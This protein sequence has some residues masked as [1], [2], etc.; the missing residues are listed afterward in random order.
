MLIRTF[1]AIPALMLAACAVSPLAANAD[2]SNS[3]AQN[4]SGSQ[5]RH[6][7]V[8]IISMF[9][10][11]GQVWLDHLGP[12]QEITVAGLSPDYPTVHCNKQDIC[13]MTTG[14]GHANAAASTMALTFS[15]KF[16]L[17][18]T[19]FMVAGIAGIDPLRGTVGSAAWAKYLVDFGIQW[20]I[21]GREIPPGWTTGYLGINTTGPTQ[22][23]PLDY[24]TEV[25][26]LNTQLADA[27]F[28]LSRNVTLED[29]AQA[30]AAR[31]KFSYA[32]ANQPPSVIQC[33]TLAGDT[34]WSGT[35]LG[36]R[37]RD[38]T[39]ILTDGKGVY[40]TT[41][42]EDNSTYEALTRAATVKRVDLSRV[43]VLRSGSDFDRPYAGQTSADNLLNYA[44]QGGF[45][46]AVD[47]LYNAG[48]PL[49]QDIATH[50]GEWRD[51]VPHR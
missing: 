1:S 47:N 4:D 22:K 17:R 43:A 18:H 27:A 9:A 2:D 24:K 36:Q 12:W 41:Q 44:A 50:W 3:F 46:I 35:D 7:K 15:P 42:Q 39:N 32:P 26:Q 40:C 11:E 37:A 10:P 38:W 31:A 30:Q 20:E 25:F 21:D 45:S 19:Y 34:W 5:A 6:V 23:P 33:D 51:G 28:A 16:D 29:N 8:M 13:V 49:V 14:M 48:N